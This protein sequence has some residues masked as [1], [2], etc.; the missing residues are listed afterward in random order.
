M[1][2]M[3][4]PSLSPGNGEEVVHYI[5]YN[6]PPPHHLTVALHAIG[7]AGVRGTLWAAIAPK[8][9]RLTEHQKPN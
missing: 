6:G 2:N 7:I 8:N 4:E 9:P 3:V 1:G 5:K